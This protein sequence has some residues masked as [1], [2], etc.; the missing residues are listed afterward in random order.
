MLLLALLL[1]LS[2]SCGAG[3]GGDTNNIEIRALNMALASKAKDLK[4]PYL[5]TYSILLGSDGKPLVF[6][7]MPDGEHLSELGYLKWTDAVLNPY[8]K[9]AGVTCAGMV[10][11]SITARVYVA[12]VD[13]G[14]QDAT[15]SDLLG[16]KAY[17]EGVDGNTTQD[18]L[19]RIDSIIQPDIDCY[20][21]MIGNNDLHAGIQVEQI[22]ANVDTIANEIATRS[23]KPVVI[24]AVMP[25]LEM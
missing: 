23:G 2:L 15:W 21:V 6:F 22:V 4:V 18:V 16:I 1:A 11:D 5:D 13:K 20:F 17:N 8:I 10:G 3:L 12:K 7:Y 9:S 25:L 19:N 24:Q 14:T